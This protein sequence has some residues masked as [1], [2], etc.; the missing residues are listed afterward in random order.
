MFGATHSSN[1]SCAGAR[2]SAPYRH[3]ARS[4]NLADAIAIAGAVD[5]D[6]AGG[7]GA[8]TLAGPHTEAK[9]C[10]PALRRWISVRILSPRFSRG[11]GRG[12]SEEGGITLPPQDGGSR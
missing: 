6:A 9:A 12:M 3:A 10:A 8:R 4:G 7:E 5:P 2:E 1:L 11:P